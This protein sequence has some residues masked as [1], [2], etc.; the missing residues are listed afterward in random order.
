MDAFTY[1][2][3]YF[4]APHESSG[5]FPVDRKY[6]RV[7]LESGARVNR[8][9]F[10]NEHFPANKYLDVDVEHHPESLLR[11]VSP[12]CPTCDGSITVDMSL[13]DLRFMPPRR[14]KSVQFNEPKASGDL[15]VQEWAA[16]TQRARRKCQVFLLVV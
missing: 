9:D 13:R 10:V 15:K 4:L 8:F 16:G 6:N 7:Q 1:H 3:W 14:R 5:L 11:E 12:K 2:S